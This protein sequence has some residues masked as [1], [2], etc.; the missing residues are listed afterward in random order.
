MDELFEAYL[1]VYEALS[2]AIR[3]FTREE[4]EYILDVLVYEGYADDYDGARFIMEAMSDEW[5]EEI[6]GE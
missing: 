2:N 6:L 4:L 5:L 3:R 1:A